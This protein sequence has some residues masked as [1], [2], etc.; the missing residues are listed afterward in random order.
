MVFLA[1]SGTNVKVEGAISSNSFFT[2]M[3]DEATQM[4]H[5]LSGFFRQIIFAFLCSHLQ[6]GTFFSSPCSFTLLWGEVDSTR[7]RQTRSIPQV[8]HLRT[9]SFGTT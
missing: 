7:I 8:D 5:F 4:D 2:V 1:A 3:L 6:L 9:R